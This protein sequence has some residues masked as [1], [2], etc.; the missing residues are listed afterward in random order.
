MQRED[1]LSRRSFLHTTTAVAAGMTL[2]GATAL[3]SEPDRTI[4]IGMVGVG[5]AWSSILSTPYSI[6]AAALPARKMGV[7]MGIFNF[8]IV[9]PQLLAATVLGLL[10]KSFFG[11][12]AI[13]AL[14]LGAASLVIAA[15]A[16]F[17]VR[18]AEPA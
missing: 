9:I 8:F 10:L 4:R 13:F 3:G 15:L 16:T 14:V 18:D 17:A 12:Q 7:Y 1:S 6:L 2:A 5:F 11:G